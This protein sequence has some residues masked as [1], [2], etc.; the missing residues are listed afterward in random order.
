[1][2]TPAAS[3]RGPPFTEGVIF[4]CWPEGA[5]LASERIAARCALSHLHQVHAYHSG[6]ERGR[7]SRA[8]S[9]SRREAAGSGA[10]LLLAR[11]P[12]RSLWAPMSRA[13]L[14]SPE[15][16]RVK[17][18]RRR[19]CARSHRGHWRLCPPRAARVAARPARDQRQGREAPRVF[20]YTPRLLLRF[21]RSRSVSAR[22]QAQVASHWDSLARGKEE[23]E[24]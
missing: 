4:C 5:W 21:G 22:S 12:A 19:L 10:L 20:V 14:R 13:E 15:W 7:C 23:E 11:P 2:S 18:P 8:A 16:P 6:R 1:M 3:G 9:Q 24:E 17:K